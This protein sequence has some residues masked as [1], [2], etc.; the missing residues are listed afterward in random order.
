MPSTM[1]LFRFLLCLLP[2]SAFADEPRVSV[3]IVP[4]YA[5]TQLMAEWQPLLERAGAAA[6]V[7]FALRFYPTIPDFERGFLRGDT[8]FIYANPWHMVMAA[9]AQGYVPLVRDR[10][11]LT[12]ILVVPAGS[13]ARTLADLDGQAI[14]F[15][16]PN[17]FGASLY[18]RAILT[19][20]AKIRFEARYVKTHANVY[21]QTALG[22]VAAGGGVNQT[23][24]SLPVTLRGQLRMLYETP[25]VA[26]HPLA[27]HPR[28]DPAL[29]ARVAAAVLALS[30]DVDGRAL[31]AAVRMPHPVAADYARDYAPREALRLDDY[32]V[33]ED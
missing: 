9:R 10:K 30:S 7:A 4:Q 20:T 33:L 17:A 2:L 27:A 28:V 21:R 6:G 18:M 32:V 13:P 15:P 3:A 5:A 31:L 11:P 26:P 24:D 12:G 25:G 23:F 14:A 8:D 1:K 16:A 22:D 29:R 19:G